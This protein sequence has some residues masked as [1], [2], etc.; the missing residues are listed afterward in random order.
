MIL[1]INSAKV[2]NGKKRP[3]KGR[4]IIAVVGNRVKL[5]A[6]EA[7]L[8]DTKYVDKCNVCIP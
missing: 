5:V 8:R 4:G 6:T 3:V 7:S 2:A 1:L